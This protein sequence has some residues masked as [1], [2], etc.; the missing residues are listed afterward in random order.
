MRRKKVGC[1]RLQQGGLYAEITNNH[2]RRR[3]LKKRKEGW[4]AASTHRARRQLASLAGRS[5]R[6][7][8]QAQRVAHQALPVIKYLHKACLGLVKG[9]KCHLSTTPGERGGVSFR[10][11][12]SVPVLGAGT[13]GAVQSCCSCG[14]GSAQPPCFWPG[15]FP[16]NTRA[17]LHGNGHSPSYG[18]FHFHTFLQG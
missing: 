6:G 13:L 9:R 7:A 5:P 11:M 10:A 16:Q 4:E 1:I 8:Q 2:I 14:A 18:A 12:C 15:R 3:E 17:L